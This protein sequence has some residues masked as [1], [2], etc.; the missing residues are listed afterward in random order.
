MS[1]RPFKKHPLKELVFSALNAIEATG[2]ENI[3]TEDAEFV[4][5]EL[6]DSVDFSA[7]GHVDQADVLRLVTDWQE[8]CE[9]VDK[10]GRD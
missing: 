8:L 10:S 1:S 6:L 4:A 5:S 3:K 7:V 2:N 9:S